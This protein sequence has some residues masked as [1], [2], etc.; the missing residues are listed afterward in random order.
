MNIREVKKLGFGKNILLNQ[1]SFCKFSNDKLFKIYRGGG[2]FDE[3][4]R[5]DGKWVELDDEYSNSII[6]IGQYKNG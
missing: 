2:S 3:T 5:K 1:K 4:G 6:L